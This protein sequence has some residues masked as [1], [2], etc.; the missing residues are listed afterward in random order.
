MKN[1]LPNISTK[2]G[3]TGTTSLY[4]GERL[5]KSNGIFECLAKLDSLDSYLGILRNVGLDHTIA[6]S[7]LKI[8]DRLIYL[9]GEIATHPSKWGDYKKK[10]PA[11]SPVDVDYLDKCGERLRT[12]LEEQE[13]KITGW[14]LYG[15]EGLKSSHIDMA[16]ALCREAEVYVTKLTSDNYI[17][18]YIN[19]L[20]DYLYW[21]ARFER[22]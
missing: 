7:I 14:V 10:Q 5:L 21:V 6:D 2:S 4:S 12:M 17:T 9:K 13:Y 1:K 22:K 11:I 8:Q 18:Q 20:S 19:R 16:R 15:D 3:D